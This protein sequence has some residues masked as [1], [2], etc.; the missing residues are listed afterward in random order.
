MCISEKE[1]AAAAAA[2]EKRTD[3]SNDGTIVRG[4][5]PRLP[6]LPSNPSPSIITH[7]NATVREIAQVQTDI[8]ILSLSLCVSGWR[9][10]VNM[11]DRKRYLCGRFGAYLPPRSL[12]LSLSKIAERAFKTLFYSEGLYL[13]G[14]EEAKTD[15]ITG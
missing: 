5:T 4:F 1:E 3:E 14:V 8:T 2:D 12:S 7:A 10:D 11:A 15:N 6:R 13:G 9:V